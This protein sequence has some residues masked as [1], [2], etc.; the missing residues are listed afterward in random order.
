MRDIDASPDN[1]VM[2]AALITVAR[3]LE[4]FAVAE[5]VETTAEAQILHAM[6]IDCLQGYLFG[7]PKF[8]F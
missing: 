8:G 5:G 4:M 2:A 3:Q 6:G 1:Q 7:V